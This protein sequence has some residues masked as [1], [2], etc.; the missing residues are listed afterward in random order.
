[1]G[2]ESDI[3]FVA[4]NRAEAQWLSELIDERLAEG[5]H[6][7]KAIPGVTSMELTR[8]QLVILQEKLKKVTTK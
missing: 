3:N 2:K 4:F 6:M 5:F 8:D 7:Y 1:M